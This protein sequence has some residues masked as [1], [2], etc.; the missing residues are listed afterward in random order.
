[1]HRRKFLGL[2]STGIG[3]GAGFGADAKASQREIPVHG[4]GGPGLD[5]LDRIMLDLMRLHDIPGGSLSLARRGRL[6]Y[7]KGFGWASLEGRV[8]ARPEVM[9]GQASVSKAITAIAVLKLVDEGRLGLEDRAFDVLRDIK[10]LPGERLDPRARAIT[11]RQLLNHSAGYMHQPDV[12]AVSRRLGIPVPRLREDHLVHFFMGRPLDY[13]PG[14]RQ[15]Y[16]NFGFA[17]LGAV[18][19]RVAG[20]PY[21]PAVHRLVFR[22]VGVQGGRVGHGAPYTPETARRYDKKGRELPPIDIPG[23]SGGGWIIATVEIVRLLAALDGSRG[24]PFLSPDARREM[25]AP[26]PPPL[27]PRGNGSWFG[28]GWDAVRETPKGPSYIKNG[29]IAGVHTEIGRLPGGFDFAIAFNGGRDVPDTPEEVSTATRS[30]RTAVER[31]TDW[32]DV[33]LFPDFGG[34]A[35]PQR[36]H[37]REAGAG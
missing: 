9:F 27:K 31:V 14:T 16:S 1:M 10:P 22:P 23:E 8:P 21:G 28:L 3:L 7:A 19:E 32:P 24:R 26:P 12:A 17:T 25:L 15:H 5:H 11:I 2:L 36:A 4:R 20:E 29:G 13:D 6:V 33:D 34:P 18:V 37:Q 35:G 30:L